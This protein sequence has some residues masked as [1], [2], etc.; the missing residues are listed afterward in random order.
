MR[1]I[2]QRLA[3]HY[4]RLEASGTVRMPK[5]GFSQQKIS[6]CIVL[7]P[8][9]SLNSI[10]D[11]RRQEGQTLQPRI[12]IV[13]GQSKPSGSGL[14][15]CFLWDNAEYLLGWSDDLKKIDRAVRAFEAS[16]TMHLALEPRIEAPA[17]AAVCAFFREWSPGRSTEQSEWLRTVAT[18]F[19]VFRIAGEQ[20]YMH[21]SAFAPSEDETTDGEETRG[22]CLVTGNPGT[23]ARLHEPKIKGVADAQTGGALLV[24]FNAPAFTSYGKEQSF[25]ATVSTIA[26]FKYANALN[27]L[28]AQRERRIRLGDATVV[29]WADHAEP[30]LEGCLAEL[31]GGM[32][33]TP[34]DEVQQDQQRVDEARRLLTQMRDGTR[35][36]A[37]EPDAVPTKFYILGLSPNAARLSVRLW[38][39]A[40]ASELER[41]L[42]EHLRDLALKSNFEQRPLS[43]R[44]LANATGRYDPKGKAKFDL[45]N[46]SPQL[47][48]ELARSV[49]TGAAYPQSF[50]G[51]M[52]RRIRSDAYIGY[53]RVSAIKACL[54]RNS[55]LRGAPQEV[56]VDLDTE[57]DDVAYRCGRLFALLEKAQT[58]SADG[59]L[60]S[61]I[62]DKYFAAASATPALVFP[63]LF[64]LNNHHLSKLETPHKVFYSRLI[65]S[66]MQA[67]FAFPKSLG[68]S[69]QGRF[70]VGYFQQMQDLYKKKVKTSEEEA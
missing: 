41:R 33:M 34:G 51:T 15:P 19:G 38:I 14:N 7:E 70:I 63:R 60:N 56:P 9:G 29:F 61:T 44:L 40:D 55:R 25:N 47:T 53:E 57:R 65:A 3:E 4:D 16:R 27:H 42:G 8:D 64:R 18:H 1:M 37:S 45:T 17:Y 59:D 43:I 67:P 35:N 52:V 31:L 48:G 21:E 6:F 11:M 54:V 49:L 5:P 10:E 13:P 23:T 68:L 66:A 20:S 46:V 32:P 39:E 24:S 22:I 62:R 58:D 50:L 12:M 30:V 69:E 26:V 2:L 28:L 36:A